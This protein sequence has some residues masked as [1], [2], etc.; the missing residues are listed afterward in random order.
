MDN[1]ASTDT[2]VFELKLL[3]R[4]ASNG[5][6]DVTNTTLSW[7]VWF[8]RNTQDLSFNLMIVLITLIVMWVILMLLANQLDA[9]Q[10]RFD[11]LQGNI[12]PTAVVQVHANE[13]NNGK[14]PAGKADSFIADARPSPPPVAADTHNCKY[15]HPKT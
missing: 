2:Q 8:Y 13:T 1:P 9:L 15:T 4:D 3:P 6:E 5:I 14:S 11:A 10:E 12:L 7:S